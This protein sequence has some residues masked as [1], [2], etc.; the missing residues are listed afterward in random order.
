MAARSQK[1]EVGKKDVGRE[2]GRQGV[3][4]QMIDR[5]ER[6]SGRQRN[7]LPCH[8]SDQDPADE[9]RTRRCG[10]AVEVLR[11]KARFGQRAADERVDDL[12]MGARGD[13]RHDAA[14]GGVSRD[15]T[16]H[17]VGKDLA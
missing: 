5:D 12:D 14:E 13:L 7:A 3:R 9:A 6:L 8:Q 15:L 2:P 10:D 4:L 11:R 16:H 17:F 1:D